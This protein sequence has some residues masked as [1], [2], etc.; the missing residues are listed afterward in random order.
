MD[1]VIQYNVQTGENAMKALRTY[2]LMSLVWLLA[3]LALVACSDKAQKNGSQCNGQII[4]GKCESN[5]GYG[6]YQNSKMG[7]GYVTNGSDFRK[8]VS[9]FNNAR[10]YYYYGS[11]NNQVQI[12]ITKQNNRNVITLTSPE[13]A[14]GSITMEGQK[15]DDGYRKI[16]EIYHNNPYRYKI[17]EL[18]FLDGEF[19][20]GRF[21]L[22]FHDNTYSVRRVVSGTIY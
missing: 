9:R 6:T 7:Y 2:F 10:Y 14:T 19:D 8:F 1:P 4:N 12:A 22:N 11:G 18:V 15:F 13:I 16:Y 3:G 17:G 21:D 20:K 5:G